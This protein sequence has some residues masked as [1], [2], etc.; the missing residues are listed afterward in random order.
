M[1][2]HDNRIPIILRKR[3][4]QVIDGAYRAMETGRSPAWT[5]R[6]LRKEVALPILNALQR[7][8]DQ[9]VALLYCNGSHWLSFKERGTRRE[10]SLSSVWQRAEDIANDQIS[11]DQRD[12]NDWRVARRFPEMVQ[13]AWLC[14]ALDSAPFRPALNDMKPTVKPRPRK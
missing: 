3:V 13:L 12:S 4:Q 2:S 7:K 8:L 5:L 1:R 9:P 10:S 6:R 11:N 14:F